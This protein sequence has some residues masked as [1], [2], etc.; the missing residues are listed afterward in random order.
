MVFSSVVFL[1]Y[2]LP[3]FL[4]VYNI[5]PHKFRNYW[6]LLASIVFY[7]WGAPKFIFVVVGTIAVDFYI[8][9]KIFH[10]TDA[11]L[12]KRLLGLSVVLKIGLLVYFK[13]VNFFID[14]VNGLLSGLDMGEI[15]W[16]K[17]ALPVG[18]SFFIF[19]AVTYSVDVY[20]KVCP[21]LKNIGDYLM[22]ILS[23]SSINCRSYCKI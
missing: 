9:K 20:R 14:N 16:I 11:K 4:L 10:S 12:R 23:V 1:A 22:Y 7:A 19:Q 18:I 21:P 5:L 6:V 8:V 13:Y 15:H 17:V 2:F 3:V